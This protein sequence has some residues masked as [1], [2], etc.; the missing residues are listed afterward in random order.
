MTNSERIIKDYKDLKKRPIRELRYEWT[1]INIIGDPK[2]LDKDGLVSDIIR[3]EYG[4]KKV[5][6]A[7][8]IK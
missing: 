3:S 7:F 1:R 4:N 8:N 5:D 2:S 6:L